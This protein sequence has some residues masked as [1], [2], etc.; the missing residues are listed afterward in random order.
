MNTRLIALI[1]RRERL[2][3][4]AEAQR[5][6]LAGIVQQWRA[7]LAVVDRTMA[8]GQTLKAHPL[9][10]LIPL[11]VLVVLR[12]SRLI[13]WAGRGWMIWRFWRSWRSSPLVRWLNY[14]K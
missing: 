10:L 9:L 3:V 1:R 13:A 6:E 2:L 7:P 11:A 12:P 5:D 8:L 14:A 4:R